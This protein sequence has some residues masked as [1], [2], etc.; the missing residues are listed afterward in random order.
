MSR[1]GGRNA[2]IKP[3]TQSDGHSSSGH[4]HHNGHASPN[5]ANAN[6]LVGSNKNGF[7]ITFIHLG[8]RG[9]TITLWATTY[10]SKKKWLEA[11][12]KQQDELKERSTVFET[13]PFAEGFC[14]TGNRV[15]CAAPFS[16]YRHL[17]VLLFLFLVI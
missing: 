16:T 15:N 5:T 4:H 8:W 1:V 11:I 7:P 9:Y 17:Y 2:L 10:I 3:S 13:V 12:Q 6:S 14:T